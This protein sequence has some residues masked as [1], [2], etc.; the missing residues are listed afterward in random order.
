MTQHELLAFVEGLHEWLKVQNPQAESV[1]WPDR[2]LLVANLRN[3]RHFW[4]PT[5]RQQWNSALKEAVRRG[6]IVTRQ[7]EEGG[8]IQGCH[9]THVRVTAAGAQ[10]LL[11][12]DEHGCCQVHGTR[13]RCEAEAAFGFHGWERAA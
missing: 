4:G 1:P 9:A 6:W 13:E 5:W 3:N 7:G 11:S 8:C 2:E 10:A 12:M